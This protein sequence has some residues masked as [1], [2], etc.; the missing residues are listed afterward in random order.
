[1]SDNGIHGSCMILQMSDNRIHELFL[2]KITKVIQKH[3]GLWKSPKVPTLAGT[4][5]ELKQ[6]RIAGKGGVP[7]ASA[8]ARA[9]PRQAC[10]R[11]ASRGRDYE[12]SCAPGPSLPK[13]STAVF[14]VPSGIECHRFS[15]RTRAA[16]TETE[17][18]VDTDGG[19][20]FETGRHLPSPTHQ[21][22]SDSAS[23]CRGPSGAP[24]LLP[25]SMGT[26]PPR[27]SLR[28]YE[29]FWPAQFSIIGR[30]QYNSM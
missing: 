1:M 30:N 29:T 17:E 4:H 25:S 3:S 12:I 10:D 15:F 2:F 23:N 13:S 8:R 26:P 20:G 14:H 19:R 28:E 11:S 18:P 21:P 24:A 5:I 6:V 9:V 7:G 27:F 22:G 16:D